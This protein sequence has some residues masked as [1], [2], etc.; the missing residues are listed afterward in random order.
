MSKK[1]SNNNHIE[2]F[3]RWDSVAF[4]TR[5]KEA[6]GGVY[7]SRFAKK[8][9]FAEGMMRK[10]LSADSVPGADKLVRIAQVSG[11]SLSWLA[12]GEGSKEGGAGQDGVTPA[13]LAVV[14]EFERYAQR[15]PDAMARAAI[16]TFVEEYNAGLLEIG[17]IADIEQVTEDELIL[18]RDIAWERRTT[19]ASIEEGIL[20]TSIEIVDEF[21]ESSGQVMAAEKKARMIVAI[22][23]LTATSEGV[24]DRSM[25][26]NLLRSIS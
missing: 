25:L 19:K 6:V 16:K 15:R 24:V 1:E 11:V 4:A 21:L 14:L 9:G 10:Y 13:Q 2:S 22:Y 23:R 8:C 17:K 26:V 5:L 18:W 20:R 7:V 12:M 3:D